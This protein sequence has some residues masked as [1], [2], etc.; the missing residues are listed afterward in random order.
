MKGF[1]LETPEIALSVICFRGVGVVALSGF[2][3]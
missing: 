1:A 2:P 3:N